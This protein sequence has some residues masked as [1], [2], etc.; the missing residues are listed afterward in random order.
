MPVR[1]PPTAVSARTVPS[2]SATAWLAESTGGLAH[3]ARRRVATSDV[4]FMVR[5]RM[6]GAIRTNFSSTQKADGAFE[7]IGDQKLAARQRQERGRLV[8]PRRQRA[9]EK[10]DL[11]RIAGDEERR[12]TLGAHRVEV[13]LV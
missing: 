10:P 8:E 7:A 2:S 6:D 1:S 3:A 11:R 13:A 9:G 4:V 12:A 5:K